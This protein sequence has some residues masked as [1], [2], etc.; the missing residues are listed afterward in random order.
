MARW[1]A[2]ASFIEVMIVVVL[3]AVTMVPFMTYLGQENRSSAGTLARTVALDLAHQMLERCRMWPPEK[4]DGFSFSSDFQD[5]DEVLDADPLLSRNSLNPD[6]RKLIDAYTYR[7]L[8]S[9]KKGDGADASCLG[10]LR[11]KVTWKIPALKRGGE[12]VLA[13]TLIDGRCLKK[14]LAG[15]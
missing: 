8:L 14:S 10:I 3:L 2:A 11:V 7:R 12:V 1:R 4:L 9:Y 6:Y 5:A 13:R 15:I